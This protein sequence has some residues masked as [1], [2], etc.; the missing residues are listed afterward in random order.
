MLKLTKKGTVNFIYSLSSTIWTISQAQPK[1]YAVSVH[2]GVI[3]YD[4]GPAADNR[5]ILD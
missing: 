4:L 3:V 5:T 1:K 2:K